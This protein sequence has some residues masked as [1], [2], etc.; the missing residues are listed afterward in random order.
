[1]DENYNENYETANQMDWEVY[2]T[3]YARDNN[4]KILSFV[5][6]E[7][8]NLLLD[9]TSIAISITVDI[10]DEFFPDNGLAAKLFKNMSIEVNSQLITLTKSV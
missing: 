7:D 3:H 10:P 9:F 2:K 4:N 8:P 5:I 1:M 6:A